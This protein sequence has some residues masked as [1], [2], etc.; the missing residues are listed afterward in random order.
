MDIRW[1]QDFLALAE[2]GNF[3]R[4]ARKQNISQAAF[5]RRIQ[6][7]EAWVGAPLVD[8]SAVPAHLTAEGLRFVQDAG[9]IVARLLDARSSV[10]DPRQGERAHVKIAMPH[11]LS[12]SMFPQWWRQWSAGQ[13]ISASLTI[14]NI[15]EIVA[16]FLSGGVDVLI[17]HQ[18]EQLPV[19]LSPDLF[20]QVL[21]ATDRFQP[22]LARG[23]AGR[24]GPVFPGS[25]G[26]P[27]P[28]LS[29]TRGTYFARLVDLIVENAP[30]RLFA[31]RAVEAT[32]SQVLLECI[33]AGL[34]VGWLP[35]SA[36][37]GHRKAAVVPVEEPGWAT[38]LRIFG[39]ARRTKRTPAA[40]ILW[41]NIQTVPV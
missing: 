26:Q 2:T 33:S 8:R 6:A 17:C 25:E 7:L 31:T 39:Y 24:G 34:G 41:Q 11:V 16:V 22:Y 29:Y 18:G 28:L 21:I 38:D 10:S 35:A 20:D 12:G 30:E 4:A 40:D 13:S 37:G 32:M 15:S 1:M 3:T 5:S 23:R 27:I 14:G 36:I 9:D 19:V